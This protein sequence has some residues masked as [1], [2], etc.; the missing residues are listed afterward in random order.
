[1]EAATLLPPSAGPLERA[2]D[3]AAAGATDLPVPLRGLWRPAPPPPEPAAT[4]PEVWTRSVSAAPAD[5][6]DSGVRL[7]VRALVARTDRRGRPDRGV[8]VVHPDN[9]HLLPGFRPDGAAGPFFL[10]LLDFRPQGD[11]RVFLASARSA[12]AP[13]AT[14]PPAAE[15]GF[16]LALRHHATGRHWDFAFAA[17]TDPRR[18]YAFPFADYPAAEALFHEDP[19]F[20]AALYDPRRLLRSP[21]PPPPQVWTDP[22]TDAGGRNDHGVRLRALHL[23][24]TFD[25]G[26]RVVHAGNRARVPAFDGGGPKTLRIQVV[27][28]RPAGDF[29]LIL[30]NPDGGRGWAEMAEGAEAAY[31]VAVRHHDTGRAWDAAFAADTDPSA[32]YRFAFADYAEVLARHGAGN[33]FDLVI[34]DPRQLRRRPPPP[35]PGPHACPAGV[36][37]WLAWALGVSD[38][39][40]AA[41]EGARRR[42]VAG[43]AREARRRGTRA[44]LLAVLR[45]AGAVFTIEER[46]AGPFTCRVRIHNSAAVPAAELAAL[47]PALRTVGRASVRCTVVTVEGFTGALAVAAGLGAA[48]VAA[49]FFVLEVEPDD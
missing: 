6:G 28:F 31:R 3:R 21:P 46:H 37:P 39:D 49:A 45:E 34:Y 27:D 15:H 25:K 40:P 35:D 33:R 1:M 42:V 16:R 20:D 36:L 26:V 38:W 47:E 5:S 7:R 2:L 13:A 17:D 30:A 12:R 11:F 24:G 18:R 22:V 10:Q 29:R 41:P 14:L 9:R 8:E 32:K 4:P 43:A 19:R 23:E 44:A 48:G